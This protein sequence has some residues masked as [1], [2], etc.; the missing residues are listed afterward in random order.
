MPV[1]KTGRASYC[2]WL[3][4]LRFTV[5]AVLG[6]VMAFGR[7]VT[8]QPDVNAVLRSVAEYLTQYEQR[9]SAVVAEE[10]YVQQYVTPPFASPTGQLLR[11]TRSLKSD[12]LVLT[13]P[14]Y[15]WVTFRD[16]F[17]VDGKPVRDRDQRLTGLFSASAADA[18]Q[19]ARAI[20][21]ESARFNLNIPGVSV[22]RSVNV[23]MAALLF[24]RAA[25]QPRSKF[26]FERLDTLQG[27]RA[28]VI[29]FEEQALPRLIRSP[30]NV[31]MQG[32]AWIEIAS[33]RVLR[34]SLTFTL[35]R[36]NAS[37]IAVIDVTYALEGKSQLWLP[38]SM[39]ERYT[40]VQNAQPM[41]V[42]SARARYSRFR[43][44]AV[45]VTQ[46]GVDAP[47]PAK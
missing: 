5:A 9:I 4:G 41:G 26:T 42:L 8:A 13:D 36:A 25:Y 35:E 2:S 29:G 20:T 32:T 47:L 11:A 21:E 28:A 33:G 46:T 3:M 10:D 27:R 18:L 45:D 34:T 37:T 24:F 30:T 14:A 23:P 7:A 22:N 6:V 38:A 43:Q 44:F 16:V 39:N 1:D 17:E 19:Q 12:V 31:P 15:G 40:S